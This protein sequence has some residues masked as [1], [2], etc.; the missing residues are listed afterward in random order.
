MAG[1]LSGF[2]VASGI[3]KA[4][5]R[6]NPEGAG[7]ALLQHRT[8]APQDRGMALGKLPPATLPL[9]IQMPAL[10]LGVGMQGNAALGAADG[11]QGPTEGARATTGQ[12]PSRDAGC[13][14][15]KIRWAW[16]HCRQCK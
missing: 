11:L 2:G 15:L 4:K 6:G 3:E 12:Q 1:Q 13:I 16:H 5:N 7:R 14:G 10:G 9:A 8:R